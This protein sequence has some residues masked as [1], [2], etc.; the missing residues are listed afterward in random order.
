MYMINRYVK[1]MYPITEILVWLL[2]LL[3]H[4]PKRKMRQKLIIFS[5]DINE[6]LKAT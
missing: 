6:F 3:L 5:I 1:C 4:Q 2:Q